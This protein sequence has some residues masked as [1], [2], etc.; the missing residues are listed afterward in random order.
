MRKFSRIANANK[1]WQTAW[2]LIAMRRR[3]NRPI[4]GYL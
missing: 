4:V 3:R 2:L 1:C